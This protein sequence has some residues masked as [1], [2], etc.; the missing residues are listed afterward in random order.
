MLQV[1]AD[2]GN[3]PNIIIA[4]SLYIFVLVKNFQI[5]DNDWEAMCI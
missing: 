2:Q 5:F 1:F 3:V 4:V